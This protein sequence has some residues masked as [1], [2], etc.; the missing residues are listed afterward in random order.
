MAY[1]RRGN[2]K[3]MLMSKS[4]TY[5]VNDDHDQP[6]LSFV[7]DELGRACS[8]QILKTS[9]T[10]SGVEV[11]NEFFDFILL[12]HQEQ[13]A[14]ASDVIN[15]MAD[16]FCAFAGGAHPVQVQLQGVLLVLVGKNTWLDIFDNYVSAYRGTKVKQNRLELRLLVKN[17]LLTL[18]IQSLSMAVSANM[19]D[20]VS[21]S[22][23]G[24]GSAYRIGI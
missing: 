19:E 12:S 18:Y 14:E 1:L 8:F 15:V 23:S 2:T 10:P 6:Q 5:F 9:D 13:H 3:P 4:S 22:L 16:T 20:A 21:F 11:P 7:N 24:I 17:T